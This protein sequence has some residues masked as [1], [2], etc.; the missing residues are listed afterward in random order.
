MPRWVWWRWAF[1]LAQGSVSLFAASQP[2]LAEFNCQISF[3]GGEASVRITA[4]ISDPEQLPGKLVEH[5]LVSYDGQRITGLHFSSERVELGFEAHPRGRLTRYTF[6]VPSERIAEAGGFRY[7]AEYAIAGASQEGVERVPL[8]VPAWRTPAGNRVVKIRVEIA[9]NEVALD[10]FP[11][12][13]WEGAHSGSVVL[14]NV[15]A[16]VRVKS[17]PAGAMSVTDRLADPTFLNDAFII[18][19]IV[20]GSIAWK[21]KYGRP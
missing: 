7:Q 13:R 3:R 11:H 4:E 21:V 14:A 5:S 19:I 10:S 6:T 8:L 2:Q 12:F 9:E 15:P 16:F 18:V 20:V 17:K 1:L